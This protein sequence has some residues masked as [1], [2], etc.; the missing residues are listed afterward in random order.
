MKRTSSRALVVP[1]RMPLTISASP[2]NMRDSTR[3]RRR[4]GPRASRRLRSAAARAEIENATRR[5]FGSAGTACQG[6]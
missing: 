3:A 1:G 2:S 4:T 6:T 5:S